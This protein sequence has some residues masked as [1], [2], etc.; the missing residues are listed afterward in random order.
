MRLSRRTNIIILWITSIGLLVGM[1]I[2]FTPTLGALTGTQTQTSAPALVVNGETIRDLEVAQ[3]RQSSPIYNV[4]SEGPVAD[5]L[6]LLLKDTLIRNEV[7]VQEAAR[8]RVGNGE[9]RTEV[10]AFRVANGVDGSRNDEAYLRLIG[11][12][13]YT[14]QTFREYVRQQLQIRKYQEEVTAGVEVNE[15]E[16]RSFYDTN[17]GAYQTDARVLARQIVVTDAELAS[18]VRERALAGEDFADLAREVSVERA[19]VGGAVGGE[20][21]QPVGRPAFPTNVA[22]AVFSRSTPGLT[23]VVENAGSFYLVQVEEV[24]APEPR[25]FDEVRGEVEA[26]ALAAKQQAALDAALEELLAAAEIEV[27]A[28]SILPV[29]DAVV[30]VVGDREIRASELARATYNNPQIQ[31]ALSPQTATLISD[32]FKPSIL[33]QLVD[34]A[35]AVQG[36]ETLDATFFGTEDLIAQSALSFVARDAEADAAE[37]AAYYEANLERY[38]VPANADVLRVDFDSAGAATAYRSDLLSGTDPDAAAEAAGVSVSDLGV[39]T[40][41]QLRS[42]LDTSLFDTEAY[43]PLPSGVREV[44]DVLVLTEPTDPPAEGEEASEPSTTM[45]EPE[46]YVVLV[47]VREAERVLPLDEVRSDVETMVLATERQELQRAWLDGLREDIK[48][49]VRLA[50]AFGESDSV[51]VDSDGTI[52]EDVL[53]GEADPEALE[54]VIEE[55]ETPSDDAGN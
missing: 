30:A 34:G 41:G 52:V 49:D 27:P 4:V 28:G 37:V 44:S 18:E 32:F 43:T 46:A 15:D 42:E 14:D 5:D 8:Q 51:I 20:E 39:V 11:G 7:V 33:E 16:V 19:D 3:L 2:T 1:V 23:P 47:A 24:I 22:T 25:P 55:L 6:N 35:L 12:A 38:T 9:V 45:G 48:V 40:R 54:E 36:A 31:Q 17:L 13:G 10:D 53:D 21:P 50:S 29:E 26:D